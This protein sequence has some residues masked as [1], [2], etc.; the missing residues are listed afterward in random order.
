[1][2]A[3]SLS[4]CFHPSIDPLA[5][6]THTH[7]IIYVNAHTYTHTT[8]PPAPPPSYLASIGCAGEG[9]EARA[10]ELQLPP[11]IAGVHDLAQVHRGSV[12]ELAREMAELVAAVAVGSW[13]GAGQ[14]LIATEVFGEGVDVLPSAAVVAAAALGV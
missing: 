2:Q 8:P 10:L 5:C 11:L 7:G 14:D 4:V 13:A 12:T 1:M 6:E 9:S 3:F